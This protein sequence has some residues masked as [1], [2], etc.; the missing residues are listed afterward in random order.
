MQAE[1]ARGQSGDFLWWLLWG[2]DGYG[3]L[4]LALGLLLSVWAFLNLAL[5][6]NRAVVL[7]QV[8]LSFLPLLVTLLAVSRATQELSVIALSEVGPKPSEFAE[9]ASLG[10]TCGILGPLATLLPALVGLAKV[11]LLSNG[12]QRAGPNLY[13]VSQVKER[14]P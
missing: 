13:M 12:A 5:V 3:L 8:F 4:I 10:L 9:S 14:A 2:G 1:P 11:A 7:V 6:R